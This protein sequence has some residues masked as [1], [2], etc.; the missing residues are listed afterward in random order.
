MY[1]PPALDAAHDKQLADFRRAELEKFLMNHR[2]RKGRPVRSKVEPA[3]KRQALRASID[4][5]DSAIVASVYR[6]NCV[7]RRVAEPADLARLMGSLAGRQAAGGG[8]RHLGRN[9]LASGHDGN[10]RLH[11]LVAIP[12]HRRKIRVQVGK[13][14]RTFELH[15]PNLLA[16]MVAGADSA[17]TNVAAAFA[18]G[19]K[20]AELGEGTQLYA[21]P[22]PN[23]SDHGSVCMGSVSAAGSGSE[24]A[25]AA[26][27]FKRI[28][29]ES[30]FT[31]HM[32]TLPIRDHKQ[33]RDVLH[34][35]AKGKGRIR[36]ADLA[37]C[38]TL[39]KLYGPGKAVGR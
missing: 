24:R 31:D 5:F 38:G 14:M 30:V 26:G 36:L 4:I 12:A 20:L 33:Y 23:C 11:Q 17:W 22:L 18:F 34:M 8:W 35:Y 7:T 25:T 2:A 10:G 28:F 3:T 29:L 27:A 6:G 15:L 13:A 37:A 19:G 39:G 16:E 32:I 21:C 1:D 9:V